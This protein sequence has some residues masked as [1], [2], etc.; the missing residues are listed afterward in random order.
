MIEV[1]SERCVAKQMETT[2]M[3]SFNEIKPYWINRTGS[4]FVS[5]IAPLEVVMTV[6]E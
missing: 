3:W 5:C 1:G 4:K 2:H 6:V